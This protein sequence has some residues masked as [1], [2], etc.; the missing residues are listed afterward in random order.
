MSTDQETQSNS[1]LQGISS[2]VRDVQVFSEDGRFGVRRDIEMADENDDPYASPVAKSVREARTA[3][4]QS[5]HDTRFDLYDEMVDLD[6]E[7]S[8]AVH[9]IAQSAS[10][11]ST[12]PPTDEPSDRGETAL[13]ECRQLV[14]E[15]DAELLA[16]DVLKNLLKYG[17]DINKK[18]YREGTGI[19][20]L[21][22]LPVN[23]VTIVD[24]RSDIR[25]EEARTKVGD[26]LDS[27]MNQESDEEELETDEFDEVFSREVY[28]INESDEGDPRTIDS[29]N[30]VHFAIDD[31]S[32]WFEDQ[33]G[34][35]TYGVWGRSRLEPLTFTIQTK[36]N[37]LTNK[38]A[39]DDKLIARE[40]YY[41]DTT[42]LFGDIPDFDERKKQAE[43]YASEIKSMI[44]GLG[45]DE[46]P[47]LPEHVN[48]EIIGPEGKAIDQQPFIEQLNNA[49]AAALT[50]PMAGLGRGTTS[51]KAGEEI[52]SLWAENNIRNLR[53]TVVTGFREIFRDHL[54]LIHNG[55]GDTD[56]WVVNRSEADNISEM[57]LDPDIEIPT[58]EYEPFKEEDMTE[59]ARQI[60]LLYQTQTASATERREHFGTLPTDEESM[61]TLKNEF[62]KIATE[63]EEK[64]GSVHTEP[65]ADNLGG[66]QE[67]SES[68]DGQQE[69]TPPD[70][71]GEQE[72]DDNN[73]E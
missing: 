8:G 68:P 72:E 46:R 17:N 22:S 13:E 52:S 49:I 18:V 4:D 2:K 54:K 32:N 58:L 11:F 57:R 63:F 39:M 62:P 12:V 53:R 29:H 35:D 44:E 55:E 20:K 71:E 30:V 66:G 67:E 27:L 23:A 56:D 48:V 14:D 3:L 5:S 61:E 36:Y 33:L 6:P 51:V 38:V 24:D 65:T 45:A 7:L 43:A 26:V 34:R 19:R 1:F 10:S 16:I 50:F 60:K 25:D 42:A 41:I 64:T 31:R 21:Q 59:K 73:G 9:A 70:E 69:E 28:V 15:I 47:M 40:I 37:T